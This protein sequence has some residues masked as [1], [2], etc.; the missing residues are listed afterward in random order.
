MRAF[1]LFVSALAFASMAQAA[2]LVDTQL[3]QLD[4][5][6]DAE[7]DTF[8]EALLPFRADD[9]VEIIK[10]LKKKGGILDLIK[11]GSSK[12]KEHSFIDHD[13]VKEE[14]GDSTWGDG[15]T[16]IRVE[17]TKTVS[18]YDATPLVDWAK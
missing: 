18:D 7:L 14:S 8:A 11:K 4:A 1:S 6:L 15:Y 13:R 9:G 16:N 10:D 3:A 5:E 2:P 17:K 12:T